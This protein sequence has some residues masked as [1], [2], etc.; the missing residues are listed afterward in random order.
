M[1]RMEWKLVKKWRLKLNGDDGWDWEEW[2]IA[3]KTEGHTAVAEAS[4]DCTRCR[5]AIC[6]RRHS[7]I[8]RAYNSRCDTTTLSGHDPT[9]LRCAVLTA[10]PCRSFDRAGAESCPSDVASPYRQLPQPSEGCCRTWQRH[11]WPSYIWRRL[12]IRHL[13][14]STSIVSTKCFSTPRSFSSSSLHLGLC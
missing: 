14:L 9:R 1:S 8:D 2:L 10:C 4:T 12:V 3:S 11:K 7:P 6:H 5:E 13:C